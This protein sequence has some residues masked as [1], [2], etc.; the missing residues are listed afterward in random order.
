MSRFHKSGLLTKIRNIL[1]IAI[2]AAWQ[3]AF[4]G[5]PFFTTNTAHATPVCTVDTAGA[6]DEP[7]QKDLTKLCIDYAGQPTSV[8]TT[9]NWDDKGS[10]GANTLDACSLFD[11]DGDGNA[12]YSVCVTTT[13]TT[14]VLDAVT[15]YSCG[16]AKNDRCT[17]TNTVI[18][19]GTTS[20]T[21]GQTSDDPFPAD[22]F[23]PTD[24]Q[25]ACTI[26][27]S[28]VGGTSAQLID[29]CS[30][31]S[32]Q[33][34]SDP[35]DCVI[36]QPK[37]GK[38]QVVKHLV[39]T[40]DGGL[41]NLQI[42]GTTKVANVSNN[43]TTGVIVVPEGNHS[44]GETAGTST[45]LTSYNSA[46]ECRDLNGTGTV[47]ASGT[48]TSLSNISIPD[49]SDIV[50]VI[51]NTVKQ[52][53]L[54]LQ[55]TVINDN[56]GTLSQSDFPVAIGGTAAQWGSNTVSPGTYTVSE[57]QQSGYQAGSWGGDCTTGG[58]VTLTPG[59]TATC[60]IT[61]N[62]IAPQLTVIKHVINDNGG[63]AS[64]SDF[65]M[66]VTGT[67]VSDSSFAGAESPG[68]TVTLNAGS[69][70]VDEGTHNGYSETKS[71]DCSGT[72]AIGET[73]TCTVTNDDNAPS[74][75]L[76]KIVSNTHGG[77][78]IESDWTLT[79]TGPTTLSG[80][81][82]A[83]NADVVSDSGFKA[84]TYTLSESGNPS[85]YSASDW[86]CSNNV[87]VTNSQIT[88]TNG[89]TTVC[90]ITNSDIAP[91]LT[92][93]KVVVNPYGTPLDPSS[94]PLFVDGISVTSGVATTQFNA[95]S[96][97]VTETQQ[98]GYTL[99]G[100]SGDCTQT[101]N[102]ISLTL[103]VGG[104]STCTLTNTA[105]Q[106]KLI[107]K[108]HVINDNGG[109][110]TAGNFTMT[111]SGNSATVPNFAGDEAGVT[112]PLNEGSYSADELAAAGYTKTLSADC[113]GTIAIGET[114]TCTITND[115]VAPS[116]T[117]NKIVSNTHGGTATEGDWT[118]T[119]TGPTTLSGPGAAGSTDVVSD[120]TF[121]AGTYTLSESG[122]PSGYS[123][124]DWTCTNNVTVTNSQITLANGQST[125]CSITNS[126]IAPS[127]TVT[128]V[129]V[130]PYGTA[131]DPSSF[132]L[133]VDGISVTS[134]VATTQFDAGSHIVTETQH[135]G[136]TL[137]GVS[138]DCVQSNNTINLT[139]SVGGTS[140][141]TLTNTAIQPK[142]TV[143]KHVINDNSGTSAAS[144][145][146]M[147][148]SGNSATVPN[149]PGNENGTTVGLNEGDY[150][151]GETSH[152]GYAETFSGDCDS[153]ISIGGTKTCTITNND[154]PNPGIHIVK[155]GPAVAHEGDK[156]TYTFT[157]T[158]TGDIALSDVTVDD[159]VAGGAVYQSG[160]TNGNSLLDTSETWT[161]T[162]N[163]TI[164]TPQIADVVN[165]ATACGDF[166]D[167]T[168]SGTDVCD[169]DSHRLDVIHPAISVEK[170]GPATAFQG[171]SVTYTFWVTNTGD[172]ELDNVGIADDLATGEVC[173]DN[174]LAP[175]DSTFCTATYTIPNDQTGDVTN[176]VTASGTDELDETVTGTDQHTLT[177]LVPGIHVVK[178][179]PSSALAGSTVTYTFTVTNTGN[180]PLDSITVQDNLAGTGVYQSGD[181][182]NDGMLETNETWIYTASY[183]IPQDQFNSVTNTVTAC[184]TASNQREEEIELET[185]INDNNSRIVCAESSHTLVIPKVLAEIT[186]PE[187]VNTGQPAIVSVIAG[188]VV[189]S[190]A[191]GISLA[192]KQS[193][194]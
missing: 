115:D 176:H 171:Q 135:S 154:I 111:V 65:T 125:V 141:C 25:A 43:G 121:K 104:T 98:S 191:A 89:Q 19:N 114:K 20:C 113:S 193:K 118:L 158:N 23:Y 108:K 153:T 16:D 187:L 116:L 34:N 145:F 58:S 69:Y 90:T 3:V 8:Q 7:N 163:Y 168:T 74:L 85:G 169:N 170:F 13:G 189:I 123:A 129:V 99:T 95:G 83:G 82:A 92:V 12:N 130:N 109:S 157:V 186:P 59:Q 71:A 60:S 27:L 26:D 79:A 45:S 178:T 52:A 180:T 81:G 185:Q 137:T 28:T 5:A 140:T 132:P 124:S 164:P 2:L 143:I 159:N 179:G 155:T 167:G 96:H 72:I 127:L 54:I 100:V 146:M 57:T 190:L 162:K 106:P 152:T 174:T 133:F 150:T 161:Y 94:F 44:V 75:T 182:D 4:A 136:Y 56:G 35:S 66:N 64:A 31:P 156:V 1:L 88:L 10:S 63:T 24:T 30:Y 142:L 76:N 138:G 29:V 87:A 50:C 80:P 48:G 119:A 17:S 42:D 107:V 103:S 68:T 110:K 148:V 101:N 32:G 165:T 134:G 84:G 21:V 122:S 49:G 73:K 22:D 41:F 53:T 47:V 46:I 181:T 6:N 93:T 86:T 139:L 62:D 188:L 172:T 37:A 70:S 173:N 147:T 144:D 77:T 15:T 67:S 9:W 61:N 102:T 39:P 97:T 151:V 128:K 33:P 184:G 160:D 105:I 78:A 55:K 175:N 183:T 38:L 11:T 177:V 126:D 18:P 192:T 149:F 14:A 194:R 117:L 120:S 36:A 166:S 91:S 112:V 131:L 40:T 51:T